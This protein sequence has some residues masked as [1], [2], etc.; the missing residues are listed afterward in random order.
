MRVI[1]PDKSDLKV[2]VNNEEI[3]DLIS[4]TLDEKR[5]KTEL[6]EIHRPTPVMTLR[7][8]TY[9]DIT[10]EFCSETFIPDFEGA[11]LEVRKD[12]DERTY[13][14]CSV[15]SVKTEKKPDGKFFTKVCLRSEK[16]EENEQ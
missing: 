5:D 1:F 8:R 2:F 16:E 3:Y 11:Q 4:I 14:N 15:K 7:G 6:F 13:K 10:L 12:S 9:C